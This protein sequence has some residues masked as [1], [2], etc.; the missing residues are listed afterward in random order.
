MRIGMWIGAPLRALGMVAVMALAACGGGGSSH[1][2]PAL[3]VTVNVDGVADSAGPLSAGETSTVEIASGATLVF[4]SPGETR[5]EP[6]TTDSSFTVNSFSFTSKS[7]TVSS[8]A[9]GTLVVVFTN[10][11]DPSQK[12]TLNVTVAAK[13]FARVARVDG[14]VESWSTSIVDSAR[15]TTQTNTLRRTVLLDQGRYG[16]EDEDTDTGA[17]SGVRNLFD[18]QDRDLGYVF[19]AT[20]EECLYDNPLVVLS[21]PLRV[22]TSWSSD[23][24]DDCSTFQSVDLHSSGTVEA[25]ERIVVPQGSHDALRIKSET[26]TTITSHEPTFPV[27]TF[28]VT[29]TCWWAVDLGRNVKC[30]YTTISSDGSTSQGSTVLTNLAR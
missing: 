26:L 2:E 11:A 29:S 16:I 24:R 4:D 20:G 18:A 14:E 17:S 23:A 10:K 15:G 13:E 5:W 9:G 6:T 21:Y 8:N 22:G 30:D 28:T 25:F 7:M 27:F 19:T 1:D 3:E 12:A